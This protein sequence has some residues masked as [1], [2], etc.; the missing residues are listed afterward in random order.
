MTIE[1]HIGP[2]I[3]R[4]Y[5][6]LSYTKWHALA[7]FVDNSTQSYFNSKEELE[8]ANKES[9]G[10][11]LSVCIHYSGSGDG[12]LIVED[13]AMG[14]SEEELSDALR[15]GKVPEITSGRSEYGM[16]MKTA[17]CWFG[18]YWTVSTK[19]LGTTEAN[20]IHFDVERVASSM[21]DLE[22]QKI[23]AKED[24]H[25]TTVTITQLNQRFSATDIRWTRDF[26]SSMYR[27]DIESGLLELLWNDEP[28]RWKYPT[29]GGN[30]HIQDGEECKKPFEF[31][32]NG[33]KVEGWI[34]IL[35]RGSREKA[36]FS[37]IRRGRVV[38]GWPDSWRPLPIFGQYEGSNDLVNQRLIG[39]IIL[40]DFGVTHTKDD[41]LW[42]KDEKNKVEQGLTEIA[43][44]Y[45]EIARSYRKRGSRGSSPSRQAIRTAV[46]VFDEEIASPRFKNIVT[47]NGSIPVELMQA[48]PNLMISTATEN[49]PNMKIDLEDINLN[50]FLS[51]DLAETDPYIGIEISQEKV[52]NI[53]INMGHPVVKDLRGSMGVLNHIKYC[54]YDAVAQWK[55]NKNW[56]TENPQV[57]RTVK[58]SLLRISR[59]VDEEAGEGETNKKD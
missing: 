16:G 46:G 35:E 1:L 59:T 32:V 45:I 34:A 11:I 26:L 3:I 31:M 19:K 6:R 52:L 5:K 15:I 10:P 22:H 47:S 25:Y 58:D 49:E 12:S 29:E 38:K 13:N 14:M 36:G 8:K 44:D 43:S 40:D 54:T 51:D 50:I 18:N 21:L 57:I 39:E 9:E 37:I 33:K 42:E 24:E 48:A 27:K 2:E 23:K 41:I 4:S 56:G 55:A 17:A 20:I 28:L 53:V 30:I 7:E